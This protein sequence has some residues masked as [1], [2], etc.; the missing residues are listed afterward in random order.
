MNLSKIEQELKSFISKHSVKFHN[1]AIRETALL[2]LGVLT[3]AS[4]HYRLSG[5]SVTVENAIE[6]LF[7]AKLSSRGHPYNFSWFRC[8]KDDL[9]YEIH[10]NLSV[11]GG[12]KDGAIYVVDV[13]VVVGDDKVPKS[14]PKQK[15]LALDND[16][17]ATFAEV[18]KLVVYP[19]LLAQFIGIVHEIMPTR[20][21]KLKIADNPRLFDRH[22]E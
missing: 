13:A 4:E 15:W 11:M 19:M 7:V 1:L 16:S 14:K 20:L 8:Q 10:S 12:H 22:F 9:V 3:M 6:G 17:L 21:K 5:F 2:E 18:K